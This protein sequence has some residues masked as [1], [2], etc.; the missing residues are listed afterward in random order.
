MADEI[1]N[2]TLKLL[3]LM[4]EQMNRMD[5]K[6]DRV[7]DD[8]HDLKMRVTNMEENAAGVHRRLDRI[9]YRLDRIEKRLDLVEA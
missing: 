6:L 3:Q 5:A 2:H 9:E 8:M 4:R 1:E 7:L